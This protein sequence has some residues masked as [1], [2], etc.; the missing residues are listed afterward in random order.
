MEAVIEV[1]HIQFGVPH[2]A[3]EARGHALLLV[4]VEPIL[5]GMRLGNQSTAQHQTE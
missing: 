5:A 4:I 3:A 1:T 2:V